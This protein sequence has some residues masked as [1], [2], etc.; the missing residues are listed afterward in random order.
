MTE[1][2]LEQK[3]QIRAYKPNSD[4]KIR[5]DPYKTIFVGRMNYKTDER[6]LEDTFEMFGK[7]KRCTIV[8]DIKTGKSRGYGFVEYYEERNAEIAYDRGNKMKID[9]AYVLVDRELARTDRF[10]LPRRLGGGKGDSRRGTQEEIEF[11]KD[12]KR[13]IK[14]EA[15][16]LQEQEKMKQ[17]AHMKTENEENAPQT[18]NLKR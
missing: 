3:K 15:K 2:I 11:V 12:I 8:K 4:K 1:H 9:G 18:S 7:I 14:K 10:W 17:N 16:D 6:R 5:G 13:E